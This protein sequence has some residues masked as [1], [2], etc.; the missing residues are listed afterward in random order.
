[1]QIIEYNTKWFR[2]ITSLSGSYSNRLYQTM[3][4]D[5]PYLPPN[6]TWNIQAKVEIPLFTGL[7]NNTTMQKARLT[8]AQ[9]RSERQSQLDKLESAIRRNL[10]T[11]MS[12]YLSHKEW[13]IAET[14]GRKNLELVTN[15]Y[16]LG[17]KNILDV[18]DAQQQFIIS[19][20]SRN[21]SYYALLKDYFDLQQ[22]IGQFDYQISDGEKTK[23]LSRLKAYMNN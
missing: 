14:A 15:Q 6:D 2:A 16:L 8:L 23:Y 13:L 17:K 7:K 11:L 18:L 5:W 10:T 22:S 9:R 20:M 1:M 12:D 3:P 19:S 21:S 4:S